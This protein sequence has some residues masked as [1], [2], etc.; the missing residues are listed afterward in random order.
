MQ[1][2]ST[3]VYSYS[4]GTPFPLPAL[5]ETGFVGWLTPS[6]ELLPAGATVRPME[7]VIYE[8][9]YLEYE[10]LDGAALIPTEDGACLRFFAAVDATSYDR[11]LAIAPAVTLCATVDARGETLLAELSLRERF[12]AFGKSWYTTVTDSA[13]VTREDAS[14]LHTAAFY[15]NVTYSNGATRVISA[16]ATEENTRS[17]LSVA[18]AALA[19]TETEYSP[20]LLEVLNDLVS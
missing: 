9:I 11:L 17:V 3:P 6:G 1:E 16:K 13:S 10:Q 19:D 5:P 2:C 15:V 7:D 14:V 12:T 4:A 18:T 20:A 8:A